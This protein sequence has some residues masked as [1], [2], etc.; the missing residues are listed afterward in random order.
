MPRQ[1]GHTLFQT[2]WDPVS[3]IATTVSLWASTSV[4]GV[5]VTLVFI[6]PMAKVSFP[7]A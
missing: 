4:F 6:R 5:S 3:E 1:A 7:R 2:S